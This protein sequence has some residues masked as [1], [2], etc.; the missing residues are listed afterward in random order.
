MVYVAASC[1]LL[2]AIL[3]VQCY[4]YGIFGTKLFLG[5]DSPGYVWLAQDLIKNGYLDMLSRWAFPQFYILLLAFLGY[6]TGNFVLAE[7]VLPL[8]FGV[9]LIYANYKVTQRITS[10]SRIA[11]LAAFLTVISLSYLRLLSDLHR[12]LMTLSLTTISFLLVSNLEDNLASR[13]G[14]YILFVLILSVIA[15]TQF[16][17]YF[18]LSLSLVLYACLTGRIKNLIVLTLTCLV[19]VAALILL[20]PAYFS[21]YLGLVVFLKPDLPLGE[22]MIWTGGTLIGFCFVLA[23]ALSAL[24]RAITSKDRL[25]LLIFSY[26]LVIFLFI[27]TVELTRFLS[28]DFAVR[29]LFILPSPILAALTVSTL[30]DLV[31]K[32]VSFELKLFST[33]RVHQIRVR[34]RRLLLL[35]AVSGLV[36]SSFAAVI[37]YVDWFLTPY[38]PRSGYDKVVTAGQYIRNNG[39]K[40]PIVV[41][42]GKPAVW[43]SSLYRNYF[44]A[45]IG[46]HFSYYGE[47]GD[48]LR[49]APPRLE[50]EGS[51]ILADREKYY[52]ALYY[53]ELIGNW[54]GIPAFWGFS[55]HSYVTTVD[56]LASHPIVVIAPECYD[57]MVPYYLMPFHR[58]EGIYIIPPGS[59]EAIGETIYGPPITVYKN[60][61]AEQVRSEFFSIDPYDASRIILRVNGSSGYDTYAFSD[62]PSSWTFV[63]I[64]QGGAPS[65]P[66]NDPLRLDATRAVEGNDPADSVDYWSTPQ[67]GILSTDSSTKKEGS[68][69]VRITGT[70]DLWGN[71]GVRYNQSEVLDLSKRPAFAVWAKANE[72]ATFSMILHDSGGNTR[73]YWDIQAYGS[74]ATQELKRFVIDL[75]DYTDQ[76]PGFD[77]TAV[78]FIDLYIHSS[79]GKQ[80]SLWV[81][82]LVVDNFPQLETAIYKARVLASDAVVVYFATR[83]GTG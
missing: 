14:R 39:F 6:V 18:I 74:S 53:S 33:K 67:D 50:F 81:D 42:Y 47:V 59:L 69:S 44:G 79:S 9:L 41:Y 72:E 21:S 24:S 4:R 28:F 68:S 56:K 45:E 62:Y 11:G 83:E 32:K 49:L 26:T 40:E 8:F 12:N 55:H 43:Y 5:W 76:T 1:F 22:I 29:A 57:D 10:N 71:L 64:E 38:I 58:G 23:G 63:R 75:S 73:S 52:S 65:A 60:G 30:K 34:F 15:G 2:S 78:D 36:A 17:T 35:I 82:D 37:L 19:P 80:M 20:F 46:E 66:E 51:S 3:L 13:R 48:L 27:L 25:A 61:A 54:S 7:W 31:T 77:L 70:T 16:E